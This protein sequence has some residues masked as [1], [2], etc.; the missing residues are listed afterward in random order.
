MRNKIIRNNFEAT[1]AFV[2][3][4]TFEVLTPSRA[5]DGNGMVAPVAGRIGH[6][7]TEFELVCEITT[8]DLIGRVKRPVHK[9]FL[10][11]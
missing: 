11:M 4:F 5:Q 6:A 7:H 9:Q 1:R 10:N 8:L 3:I 2:A